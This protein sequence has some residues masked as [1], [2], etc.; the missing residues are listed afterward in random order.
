M[1]QLSQRL[2]S[3]PKEHPVFTGVAALFMVIF[4]TVPIIFVFQGRQNVYR[5]GSRIPQTEYGIVFGA[6]VTENG[7]PSAALRD[8]LSTAVDLFEN[9]TISLILVSGD[10]SEGH[11]YETDVM[12]DYL[13]DHGIPET[14]IKV[15][16]EGLRTYATCENAGENFDIDEALLITQGFH[17]PRAIFLCNKLGVASTGVSATQRDY[18]FENIFKLREIFAIYKSLIDIYLIPPSS[19]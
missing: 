8:R 1:K 18:L 6:G 19:N 2:T 11:H 7:T 9:G 12:R 17:L 4:I 15:D 14:A 5:E 16:E 10:N 3:L 13:I